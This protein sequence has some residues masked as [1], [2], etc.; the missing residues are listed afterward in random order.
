[1]TLI[2]LG[3][4]NCAKAAKL[5]GMLQPR[6]YVPIDI[7]TAFLHEAVAALQAKHP[8]IPII[9]WRWISPKV[10]C[11]RRRCIRGAV[12]FFY[13]GSSLGNLTP[14]Q[15]LK[16][17]QRIRHASDAASDAVLIGIDLVKDPVRLEAAYDD[18]L[19]VTAAFNRN[20]LRHVNSILGADFAPKDWQHRA[21][22]NREQSRI[23][24]CICKRRYDVTVIGMAAR[25]ASR[26][27]SIFIPR[28][29]I[30]IPN[31]G[32]LHYWHRLGLA[33]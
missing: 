10:F 13:P 26:P 15:A 21:L 18:E 23:E 32:L 16:F 6:Q 17:M 5:F 30:N 27:V 28:T 22:F 9:R 33:R 20:I 24:R 1:M 14:L 31:S 11:S 2:D 3:S 25:A 12:C 29:A 19:G 7:S 8:G 4:G